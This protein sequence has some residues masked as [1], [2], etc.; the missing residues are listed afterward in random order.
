M[1]VSS[2]ATVGDGMGPSRGMD[3]KG[4]SIRGVLRFAPMAT[5]PS[6]TVSHGA[7]DGSDRYQVCS[8]CIFSSRLSHGGVS[9]I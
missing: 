4:G 5:T 3:V 1:R 2:C 6:S 9:T 8:L 7:D